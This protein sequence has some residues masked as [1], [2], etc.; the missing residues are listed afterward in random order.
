M[1]RI[2]K[3]TFF[4]LSKGTVSVIEIA[5]IV[6]AVLAAVKMLFGIPT[7]FSG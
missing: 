7:P 2:S 1:N 6:G 3:R 4:G 5:V